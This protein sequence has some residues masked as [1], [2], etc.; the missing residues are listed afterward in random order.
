MNAVVGPSA[1]G[2]DDVQV[3]DWAF[4]SGG[5]GDGDEVAVTDG[6]GVRDGRGASADLSPA[7]AVTVRRIGTDAA[8]D[9]AGWEMEVRGH[10]QASYRWL[11]VIMAKYKGS[12]FN[13]DSMTHVTWMSK[14]I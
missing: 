8:A 4:G 5:V 3:D 13:V 12:V 14:Q 7:R 1:R 6:V 9:M 2:F 11:H 10:Y